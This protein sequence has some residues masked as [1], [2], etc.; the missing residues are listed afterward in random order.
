[1]GLLHDC[2][3]PLCPV[4]RVMRKLLLLLPL[5]TLLT[6]C[7]S[8]REICAEWASDWAKPPFPLED[9][10]TVARRLG[11]TVE[12]P[13]DANHAYFQIEAYCEYFKN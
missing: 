8:K 5:I 2:G 9:S 1:M 12:K 4:V 13:G 11:I 10:L 6:A 3:L 7:Q